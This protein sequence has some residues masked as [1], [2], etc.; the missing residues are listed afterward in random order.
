MIKLLLRG[1][2]MDIIET[3]GGET[4]YKHVIAAF[5]FAMIVNI[6]SG[7]LRKISEVVSPS[8]KDS[9]FIKSR[10]WRELILPTL[11][12]LVG[13]LLAASMKSFPYPSVFAA[14]LAMR[15]IYGVLAGFFSTW[16][17]RIVKTL[18]QRKWNI[19]LPDVGDSN[20]ASKTLPPSSP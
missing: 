18:V 9:S 11:P 10:I 20:S 13:A 2:K 3:L 17:Y 1:D 19:E 12:I 4:F 16:A 8:L 6:I 14:S 5:V 15:T 7:I